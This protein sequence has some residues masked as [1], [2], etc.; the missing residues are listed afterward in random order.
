[1][2]TS[3]KAGIAAAAAAVVAGAL[4][5]AL[6]DTRP[7][8]RAIGKPSASATVPAPLAAP[9]HV[10]RPAPVVPHEYVAPGAP[11][12]FEIEG[13]AFDIKAH[14]CGMDYVRPLDPPGE[15]FHTVC[16]VQ[17]DFGVAPASNAKGTSYIL[18]HAWAEA[19]LVLNKLSIFAM[20]HVSTRPAMQNGIPTYPV[21]GLDGYH[22]TLRTPKGVLTYRVSAAYTVSKEQ[23]GNVHALMANTPNRVVLITCGVHNGVDVDVNVIVYATLESS[24]AS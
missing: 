14:V 10:D 23:A 6:H 8:P 20:D 19:S 4:F 11:T 15:Q 16:W 21:S 1:M 9:V 2:R 3:Y 12:S 17:R 5:Y 24:R 18:G 22:V 13:K 7:A